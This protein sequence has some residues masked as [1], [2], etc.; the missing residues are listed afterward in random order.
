[1]HTH[2]HTHTH[3]QHTYVIVS[4]LHPGSDNHRTPQQ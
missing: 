1:M 3:T 4:W 2:T